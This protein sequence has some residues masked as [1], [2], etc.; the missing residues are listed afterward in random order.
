M[1]ADEESLELIK[2]FKAKAGK[3]VASFEQTGDEIAKMVE[4]I[5]LCKNPKLRYPTNDKYN[6]NERAAKYSDLAG[7]GLANMLKKNYFE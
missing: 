2:A 4:E 7:E 6:P 5:I 3:R 1:K